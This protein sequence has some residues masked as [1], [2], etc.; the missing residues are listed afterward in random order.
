MEGQIYLA[1]T[2]STAT[3]WAT[4]RGGGEGNCKFNWQCTVTGNTMHCT[5][6]EDP[7]E[8]PFTCGSAN[9]TVDATLNGNSMT[10][11]VIQLDGVMAGSST[12]GYATR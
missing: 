9:Q 4:T 6:T 11:V 5:S 8:D 7:A 3:G 10:F 1:Q 12:T 2:G